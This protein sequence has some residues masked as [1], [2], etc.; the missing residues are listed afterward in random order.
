MNS[1]VTINQPQNCTIKITIKLSQYGKCCS[2]CRVFMLLMN[3]IKKPERMVEKKPACRVCQNKSRKQC[4]QNNKE[5]SKSYCNNY[6]R[7]KKAYNKADKPRRN[8]LARKRW[9]HDEE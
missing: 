6:K 3:I 2:K 8:E 9:E 7:E 5:Q 1:P 4:Y